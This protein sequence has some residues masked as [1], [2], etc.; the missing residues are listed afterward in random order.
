MTE[1]YRILAGPSKSKLVTRTVVLSSGV[2]DSG[3]SSLN[4]YWFWFTHPFFWNGGI[5][6]EAAAWSQRGFAVLSAERM[7]QSAFW[8]G[9]LATAILEADRTPRR[10][11][12]GLQLTQTQNESVRGFGNSSPILPGF[13]HPSR[14][15]SQYPQT[16]TH[17][18]R[19]CRRSCK[20]FRT[21]SAAVTIATSATRTAQDQSAG[22]R[23]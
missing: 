21:S 2:S 13:V 5:E 17:L 15:P 18:S 11:L 1:G 16:H 8:P 7:N 19:R 14:T 4:F 9:W 10:S 6:S 20:Y 3:R 22:K 23:G 12:G